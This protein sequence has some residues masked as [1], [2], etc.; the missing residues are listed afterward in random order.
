MLSALY[1]SAKMP[2]E[3]GH[4]PFVDAI[5]MPSSERAFPGLPQARYLHWFVQ[6]RHLKLIY[7]HS[8]LFSRFTITITKSSLCYFNMVAIWI[9][10]QSHQFL[11]Y[12]L[13]LKVISMSKEAIYL[14]RQPSCTY[15]STKT[16]CSTSKCLIL[17]CRYLRSCCR[18]NWLSWVPLLV[19]VSWPTKSFL[20]FSFLQIGTHPHTYC[21]YYN[22]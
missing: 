2:C 5:V 21:S 6:L 22:I 15:R 19:Q 17:C 14:Q 7:S 4:I 13:W 9:D 20:F 16:L 11:L 12:D 1:W 10:K 8:T 3:G 18:S